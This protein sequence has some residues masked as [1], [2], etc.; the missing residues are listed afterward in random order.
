MSLVTLTAAETEQ[1]EKLSL[2]FVH[3]IIFP[4]HCLLASKYNSPW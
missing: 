3:T 1:L 2:L 4:T